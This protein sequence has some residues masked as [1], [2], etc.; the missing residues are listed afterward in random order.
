MPLGEEGA[1]GRGSTL[2]E[3][4][5]LKPTVAS[6]LRGSLGTSDDEDEKMTLEPDTADFGQWVK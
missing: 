2:E 5:E 6:F 1:Q 3:L 4:L